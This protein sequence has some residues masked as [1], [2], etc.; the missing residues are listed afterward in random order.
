MG[1]LRGAFEH[2]YEAGC[3]HRGTQILERNTTLYSWESRTIQETV[4]HEFCEHFKSVASTFSI[5]DGVVMFQQETLLQRL[6]LM[7][8]KMHI[9]CRK[10]CFFKIRFVIFERPSFLRKK[11]QLSARDNCCLFWGRAF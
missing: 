6:E 9:L 3:M 1:D 8:G 7:L 4:G 11:Q 5:F 10:A 2:Y